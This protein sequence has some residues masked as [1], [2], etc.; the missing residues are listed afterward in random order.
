[1]TLI[2]VKKRSSWEQYHLHREDFGDIEPKSLERMKLSHN[3]HSKTVETVLKAL[4][5]LSV[6]PWVVE[7]AETLFRAM[8]GDVVLTVGGDGTFLS[9]SHNVGS[10]VGIMGIN[11]D[12]ELSRGRFCTKV[13]EGNCGAVIKGALRKVSK[14]TMV[15]RM[16]VTVN[17]VE[18]SRRVLNEALYS[19]TCPAAMTRVV[20]EGTRYAC[21]GLWIGTGAG[22]T[23]AIK[24]AGGKV[25]PLRSPL[26]QTIV[27]EPC[28]SDITGFI[29]ICKKKFS[30]VSKTTDATLYIDG[31]FLRVPV[32]FDQVM[33]FEVSREPLMM[34]GPVPT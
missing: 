32:G 17:G 11:S 27:R 33:D 6:T 16:T 22:S 34:L 30:F 19:H 18:V 26:L 20:H 21:S 31:P 3:R 12:P 14:K 4:K 29:S 24:S 9:A 1:M 10:G 13:Y 5:S 2:L 25:L 7:G 23:G 8:P 15:P 28:Q